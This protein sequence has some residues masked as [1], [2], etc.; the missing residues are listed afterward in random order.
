MIELIYNEEGESVT[1]EK[2]LPEP[3]NV[4]QV[5]EPKDYKKIFIEDYVHTFL[6]QYA[7]GKES[8]TRIA[9]LL[10]TSERSGGKRHLYIKSAYPVEQ[11]TEKQGKYSFTEKVWG[12]VYQ[13]CEKY[14]SDQEILG[15]FL[16]KPGFP[17]EKT[18]VIEETHRTY[19]S[20][21]DKILFMIEP[22]EHDSGFFAFDGNRFTKQSGYY[23]YYEKNEPMREFLMEKREGKKENRN[24]EKPDVAMANFR[25]ILKEKQEKNARRKK[26]MMSYGMK[27]AIALVF[28]VGAVALKNQTD[29]IQTMEEQLGTVTE[30]EIV[31]ETVSDEV[32]VEELPGNVEENSEITIEELVVEE[33]VVEEQPEEELPVT[34]EQQEPENEFTVIEEPQ[35]I[36][37]EIPQEIEEK[38]ETIEESSAEVPVEA[39][40][41]SVKETAAEVPAY[42]EYIVQPGDTLAKICRDRYGTDEKLNEICALNEIPNGDY[43]QVGEIILLP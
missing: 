7:A 15:W 33:S 40:E 22:L 23:I 12:N 18:A 8:G 29:K 24:S 27:V 19:F 31:Q 10:G 35:E 13:E 4:K 26:Q 42:E 28:F 1:E 14:F 11:V 37:K 5:G 38:E 30:K 41:E 39:S 20:G 3:K 16:A 32:V 36:E 9:V 2:I 25:R 43:I 6:N 34:E 21:A 17:V